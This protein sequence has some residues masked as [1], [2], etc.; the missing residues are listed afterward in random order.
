MADRFPL[1]VNSTS[2]KI[3]ELVSGDNLE[4]TGN[5]LIISGDSGAGKY[6]TSDGTTVFWGNPGDV[7]LTQTQTLTNKSLETCTI[8]G[9]LNTIT[10]LPNTALTNSGININGVSVPLGGSVTTPDTNTTYSI[11][12]QDGSIASEKIIR[13]TDSASVNDDVKLIAGSNMTINRSGDELTFISSYV[14]TDTITTLAAQT[15]GT[16]QSGAMI[17]AASGAATV[18]QDAASKTITINSVDTDTITRLRGSTGNAYVDGDITFVAAGATSITQGALPAPTSTPTLEISST[19]TV[20]RVKGG[21]TGAFT[22]GDL[23]LVGGTNSS[24]SQTGTTITVDSTDTDTVTRIATGSNA[25]LAGDFKFVA[26]GAAGITQSTVGGVTTI[27]IS[28]V[29]TDSGAAITADGGLI[30]SSSNLSLKNNTNLVG[31]TVLKWDS[32]NSQI[33]N[34]IIQDDG[35]TVTIGGDLLVTGSQTILEVATL[36]V[37]DN[38]I[39]LRKGNSLVGSDGGIQ[40]NRTT[41]ASG[42]VT[43]YQRLEWYESGGYWRTSDGSLQKEIINVSDTQTLTNKTLTN[44]TLSTPT[45]GAATATSV[46]GLEI[47]P[48]A[49]SVLTFTDGKTLEVKR[50]LLLTSDNNLASITVGFRLGGQVAYTGDTLAVFN[51]TTSDQLRGLIGDTT[52]T[53]KLVFQDD[54][55]ILSGL[56]TTSASLTIFNSSATVI[57]SFG[58][59]TSITLGATSGTTTVNHSL[60]VNTDITAGVVAGG[61][62]VTGGDVLIHGTLNTDKQDILIRGTQSDPMSIGRGAGAV[63]TNTRVGV[64]CLDNVSSGS[65]NTALGYRALLTVNVGASNTAVGS[66]ALNQTGTGASN[67]AIGND[68]LL[69]NTSGDK[70]CALGTHSLENNLAGTANVCIGHY[71]GYNMT[72][73]GNVIIGPADDENSTNATYQPDQISGDRQLVIGSGTEAWI[74]GASNFNI[75]VPKDLTVD[76]DLLIQGGLTVNGTVTSIN[77]N[78]IQIDDK[79]L[80]LAAVVTTSFSATTLDGS[81]VITAI[82]PTSNLIPGMVLGSTTGG[83]SVPAG[84][85][86]DTIT[87]NQATLSNSVTGTGSANFTAS[88][89]SDTAADGGGVIVKGTTNHQILY[90]NRTSKFFTSSENFEL[91]FGKE[92]YINNQLA[93]ST[94]TLGPTVVNSSLTSVGVLIG[95]SGSPALEVDGAA[96]LGGRVIEKVFSSFSTNFSMSGN[97]ISVPTAGA[98]TVCGTT[99]TTAINTWAFS[100]ADADNNLLVNGQSITVTLIIEANAAAT[101][102]D[103]CTVD[104]NNV[105]NGVQWSGGSPPL[106]TSNTDILSFIILKDGA[107]VVRVYGQGNTDFS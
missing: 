13:L 5:G 106:A 67:V 97:T 43:S 68:A 16:A 19:D 74:K 27:D 99:P 81:N 8:S 82:T 2:R 84:T 52:G 105:A 24:I 37:E 62:G 15:G 78:I 87:D 34:S 107:G 30:F 71:A 28:S 47:T 48:C 18:S 103:A 61:G 32:G 12:L 86:I 50:D 17:I 45:L 77:S 60:Q 55:I 38:N 93:L 66:R 80:E 20:T 96:V 33:A 100:T 95:P 23:T 70:N 76:G 1:I 51:S 104:G 39:E 4:L 49:S 10:N 65:Q 46:N 59:A 88:G 91:A 22:S 21:T 42:N 54:P 73:T 72:G 6:L 11:S 35:S 26:S 90:D 101:Y 25:V 98:N 36:V 40:V 63:G 41:D 102:G 89:P 44:P 85:T 56:T 7:Y 57:T 94:T 53:G 31:N 14:D 29:N 58:A 64:A 92:Y 3:E 83:I 69:S 79:N 75:T 9:T